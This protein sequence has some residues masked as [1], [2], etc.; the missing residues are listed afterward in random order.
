MW[1]ILS[2]L[3]LGLLF[4]WLSL[5]ATHFWFENSNTVNHWCW[6]FQCRI[7]LVKI[8][9]ELGMEEEIAAFWLKIWVFLRSLRNFNFFV[10]IM[11]V[12]DNQL[13]FPV[14]LLGTGQNNTL[15]RCKMTLLPFWVVI[16]KTEEVIMREIYG[17]QSK[18]SLED[19]KCYK[20]LTI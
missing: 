11:L 5:D 16:V 4:G 9:I 12:R 13:H 15:S 7:E 14:N 19:F 18:Q 20:R 1:P 2:I 8:A 17:K 6:Y 10:N 3:D